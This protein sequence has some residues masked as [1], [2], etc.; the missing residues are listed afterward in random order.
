MTATIKFVREAGNSTTLKLTQISVWC[1]VEL[2]PEKLECFLFIQG[3]NEN[4]ESKKFKVANFVDFKEQDKIL[5]VYASPPDNVEC[6]YV[7]IDFDFNE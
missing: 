1:D 3:R 2:K 6:D 4:G 5:R 7:I